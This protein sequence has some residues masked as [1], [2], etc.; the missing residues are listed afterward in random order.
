M[1]AY[2]CDVLALHMRV[3]LLDAAKTCDVYHVTGVPH[4]SLAYF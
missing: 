3:A 4:L 2:S 1:L